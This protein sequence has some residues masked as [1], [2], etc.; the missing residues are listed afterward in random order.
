M[1]VRRTLQQEYSIPI[2]E[3]DSVM[4]FEQYG[5]SFSFQHSMDIDFGV[6]IQD[7]VYL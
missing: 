5:V 3:P 7:V 1:E 2:M 6:S 4:T